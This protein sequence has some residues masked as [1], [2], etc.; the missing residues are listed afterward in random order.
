MDFLA[1]QGTVK[2]L[3]LHHS[4]KTSILWNSAFIIVQFSHPYMT[5]GKTIDLTTWTFVGKV[6]S[7]LFNMIEPRSPAL[8]VD[9]LPA[10]PQGKP[11]SG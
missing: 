6:M 2:G 4:S 10:E 7:V 5:T 8:Q 11:E 3:L 1:T 9:S